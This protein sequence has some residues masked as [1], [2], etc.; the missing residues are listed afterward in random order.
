[1]QYLITG[2]TGF[3]GSHLVRRLAALQHTCRCLVKEDSRTETLKELGAELV[4]GDIT[5]EASLIGIADG[6]DCVL[7]LATLGHMSNFTVTESLFKSVNVHGTLNIM[8][9]AL[10]SAVK[11]IVHCSTVAAM[12][13]CTDN[14]ATEKSVCNPHHAYGRS[15]REAEKVVLRLVAE[16][17]LPA[18][19]VRF[20]MVYGPGDWRDMLKLVR[21]AQ[22]GLFPKI[23]NR[24]K[25]TPLIHVD[26]AVEGLL[27]AACKGRPG[28]IYLL[29]NPRSE[30]FDK[31]RKIIQRE[32]NIKRVPIYVP[33]W[34]ALTLAA[35]AEKIYPLMGKTPPVS[36]KNIESTLVDRVF[37]ITKAQTELGFDPKIDPQTGLKETIEWYRQNGWI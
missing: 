22:K 16:N 25:L 33:E 26:D 35:V 6:V 19:I 28:E 37:S 34:A 20:S 32:L 15:K 23:G 8:R 29:T 21:M 3:I 30:P 10:N 14:P 1:L 11:K 2:A 27:Q 12:G 31:I 5:D 24:P 7:H 36:K 13:I 17:N 9:E 18:V 4:R